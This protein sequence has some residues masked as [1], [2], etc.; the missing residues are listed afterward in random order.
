MF[1]R[2]ACIALALLAL[3]RGPVGE[4]TT[5]GLMPRLMVES[6]TLSE[7]YLIP[8]EQAD[9]TVKLFNT[10]ERNTLRNIKVTIEDATGDLYC[11]EGAQLIR[12][13]KQGEGAELTFRLQASP[14]AQDGPHTLSCIMEYEDVRNNI[15][16]AKESLTVNLRQPIR[17]EYTE[18]KLPQT[19]VQGDTPALTMTLM[20]MGKGE[21]RNALVTVEIP[22]LSTGGSVLAGNIP[23]GESREV[24]T[25]LTVG[26][27]LEG[28][29][30]G[31]VILTWEDAYGETYRRSIPVTTKI[32][33][34]VVPVLQ[35][36]ETEPVDEFPWK[37]LA[38]GMC[39]L[40]GALAVALIVFIALH[41]KRERENL[42]KL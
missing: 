6:Y 41:V 23:S 13:I 7:T 36:E 35:Q 8:G 24:K 22:G 31:K 5:Q 2:I 20:N 39:A 4:E 30:K 9:L 25:N 40:S 37:T 3:L 16:N 34:K 42:D 21:I 12:E 27:T 32:E 29:T 33:K 11:P 14:T 1:Y 15:L 10:H 28:N 17:L 26:T 19:T 38:I 18:P